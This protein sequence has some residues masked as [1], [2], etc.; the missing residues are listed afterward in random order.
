MDSAYIFVNPRS[1]TCKS[2]FCYYEPCTLG[3]FEPN[4]PLPQS[5]QYALIFHDVLYVNPITLESQ[6]ILGSPKHPLVELP[7]YLNTWPHKNMGIQKE[8]I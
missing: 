7:A 6:Y 2:A 4:S 3:I 5:L 1:L 8:S